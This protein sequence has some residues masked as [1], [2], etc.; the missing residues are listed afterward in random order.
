MFVRNKKIKGN[1]YY[2]V[3]E[4]SRRDGVVEQKVKAYLGSYRT[5]KRQIKLLY[6]DSR[7]LGKLLNRLEELNQQCSC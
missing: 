1:Q 3:V 7:D 4:N 6:G 2:Y 5:A